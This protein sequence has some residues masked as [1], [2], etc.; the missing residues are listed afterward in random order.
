MTRFATIQDLAAQNPAIDLTDDRAQL[1]LAQAMTL[2]VQG[3]TFAAGD[4][5]T[6]RDTAATLEGLDAASIAAL[7][8]LGVDG[9]AASDRVLALNLTQSAALKAAGLKAGSILGDS[10]ATTGDAGA[11]VELAQEV[12]EQCAA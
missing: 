6:V 3:V 4:R 11:L 7:F 2:A 8:R 9:I 1:T 5:V 10:T 12:E